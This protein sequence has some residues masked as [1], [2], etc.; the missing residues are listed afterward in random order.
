MCVYKDNFIEKFIL[1]KWRLY[2]TIVREVCGAFFMAGW[3][4]YLFIF[5][6][7][8]FWQGGLFLFCFFVF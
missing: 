5:I 4:I 1:Q 6:Y 3:V 2:V 7:L 8:F